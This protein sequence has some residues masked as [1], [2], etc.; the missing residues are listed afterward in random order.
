ML[1]ALGP[2]FLVFIL[3]AFSHLPDGDHCNEQF[4]NAAIFMTFLKE[5]N[6]DV[7]FFSVQV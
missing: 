2:L 7:A 1:P 5:A 3:Q 4:Q 6:Q